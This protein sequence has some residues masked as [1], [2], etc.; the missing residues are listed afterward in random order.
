MQSKILLT[1]GQI[2]DKGSRQVQKS[3][4]LIRLTE[5]YHIPYKSLFVSYFSV[6]FK[7]I[8]AETLF[9]ELMIFKSK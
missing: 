4:Q 9:S 2:Y 6:K 7:V 3:V 8:K 5:V 1:C